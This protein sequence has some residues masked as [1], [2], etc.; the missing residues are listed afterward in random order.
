MLFWTTVT[1]TIL[2]MI[3]ANALYVAAEFATV[4]ARRSRIKEMAE[5]GNRLAKMLL[6][7][8]QDK[9][10]LDDYVAACQVG[11]TLS[12]LVLGAY[13]Q[14]AIAAALAPVLAGWGFFADLAALSL[15]TGLVL[16]LLSTLQ[17]MFGE[18]LPKSVALQYPERLAL[19]TV[20]PLR[21]SLFVFRPLIWFLNGS[22]NLILSLLRVD[23]D[24]AE[25]HVHS[26]EEIE[27]V[28]SESH[29]GGL[30]D[31]QERQLLRNALHLRG[32]IARQV[33]IPR[34]QLV[35]A[36]IEESVETL[37]QL[38]V[39]EGKTRILVYQKTLDDVIGFVHLKDLF[40][41]YLA[42]ET[43]SDLALRPV[44]QIPETLPVWEVW[45]RLNRK[46]QYL[47]VVFDEYGG[48]AGLI[49][50]EDLIEEVFGEVQDEFDVE[51]PPMSSDNMGR[52]HLRGDLLVSDVNEYLD[53]QLPEDVADTL[54]GLIFN[55]WGS[56]PEVGD[57]VTL[58]S[59]EVS[60]RVET[61]ED[62]RIAEVSLLLPDH[63]PPE[64]KEWEVARG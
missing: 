10:A 63:E 31:A 23:Y 55:H 54:G 58:G 18:L 32:L 29:E 3:A 39:D 53:L 27:L 51:T 25:E 50:F 30:L 57:E 7:V 45:E 5:S 19:L 42:G 48:V 21:W 64:V 1:I 15:S 44:E 24:Q 26:P 52:V 35:A 49:T 56:V 60:L 40:R 47:A 9:T 61:V 20:V 2:L 36:P 16:I 34:T 43:D 41:L 62:R 14:S 22:G 59:P 46:H 11:I 38:A 33:M 4:S 8:V 37:L 28:V 6:P 13:G 17:V 12:S